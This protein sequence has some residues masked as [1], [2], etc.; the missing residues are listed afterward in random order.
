MWGLQ[1]PSPCCQRRVGKRRVV[2]VLH[3][4]PVSVTLTREAHCTRLT[5]P[6][7]AI[8]LFSLNPGSRGRYKSKHK[9]K[10]GGGDAKGNSKHEPFAYWPLD[11]RLT[12]RRPDKQAA[13]K[14]GLASIVKG[15]KAG[16]KGAKAKRQKLAR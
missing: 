11:K 12:N 13:A 3:D 8:V 4:D 14:S 6:W 16:L 2:L 9:G 1:K 10:V 7:F 15:A 5:K